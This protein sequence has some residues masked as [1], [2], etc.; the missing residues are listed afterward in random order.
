MGG[1]ASC[2]QGLRLRSRPFHV[3]SVQWTD[4]VCADKVMESCRHV[5]LTLFELTDRAPG[6][7]TLNFRQ[8]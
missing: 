7:Q 2:Q 3:L 8:V 5:N 1:Y 6:Q 4:L